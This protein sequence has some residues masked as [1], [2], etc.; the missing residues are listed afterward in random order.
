MHLHRSSDFQGTISL[1]GRR[2]LQKE[3]RHF[4]LFHRL[5]RAILICL[6]KIKKVRINLAKG[7][8]PIVQQVKQ[9]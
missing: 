6:R 4:H 2:V 7:A 3:L 1:R 8:C 5:F 9:T